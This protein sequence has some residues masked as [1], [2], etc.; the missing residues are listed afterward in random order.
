MEF[1]AP[2]KDYITQPVVLPRVL[3]PQQCQQIIDLPRKSSSQGT[4]TREDGIPRVDTSARRVMS[5]LFAPS[6]EKELIGAMLNQI[7]SS[8]NQDYFQF[9][10][11]IITEPLLL[12]YGPD[13]FYDWHLDLGPGLHSTRKLSCVILLSDPKDYEGGRLQLIK[14]ENELPNEQGTVIVFPSFLLHRVAPV[15]SGTRWT[16]AVWAIGEPFT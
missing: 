16:I 13:G 11:S 7:F 6:P 14:A 3:T 15:L 8:C 5:H 4:V 10:L 2:F 1:S 9:K 12:E